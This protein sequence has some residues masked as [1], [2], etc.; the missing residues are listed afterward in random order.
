MIMAG[1]KPRQPHPLTLQERLLRYLHNKSLLNLQ[2][3]VENAHVDPNMLL[4][5]DSEDW[6]RSNNG[7]T[8]LNW[9][10]LYRFEPFSGSL[11]ANPANL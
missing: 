4:L 5:A 7:Y 11:S 1:S 2:I 10:C 9:A 8:V 6:Y 3:A